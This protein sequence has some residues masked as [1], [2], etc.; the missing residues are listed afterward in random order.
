MI[1]QDG[2]PG[3]RRPRREPRGRGRDQRPGPNG[4][5]RARGRG[6]VFGPRR[7][8]PRPSLSLEEIVGAAIEVADRD[9]IN[10]VTMRNVAREL[11]AGAMSL[12]WHVEN[13]TELLQL[14][15]DEAM[16]RSAPPPGHSGSWREDL[17]SIARAA[18][19][20]FLAHPWIFDIIGSD[21]EGMMAPEMLME[22]PGM[23]QH[24]ENSLAKTA[25]LPLDFKE[26][27]L[28][29]N[30]V[31]DFTLGFTAGEIHERRIEQITG[32]T[33]EERHEMMGPRVREVLATG[34]YPAFTEF[35]EHDEELPSMDERF[36]FALDI[37]LDGIAARVAQ[38]EA[39]A[40]PRSA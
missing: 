29:G 5:D 8:E 12:Y 6:G 28:I 18:R 15:L 25:G 14:M 23:L 4:D 27:A 11:G 26:R 22:R 1:D 39:A 21:M 34:N 38:A 13:K 30:L 32:L 24:I 10:A 16:R 3:A 17:A 7:R 40:A 33:E 37:I 19:A 2:A 9:G 35:V 20:N 31:D 36:E